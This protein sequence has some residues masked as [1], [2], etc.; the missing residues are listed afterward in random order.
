M[1]VHHLYVLRH[2]LR[3]IGVVEEHLVVDLLLFEQVHHLPALGI[4]NLQQ[5]FEMRNPALRI[6]IFIILPIA[7]IILYFSP[8]HIKHALA[9]LLNLF[10][11]LKF[12]AG[13]QKYLHFRTGLGI[14]ERMVDDDIEETSYHLHS[15]S[16]EELV[17]T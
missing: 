10:P 15:P 16:Y 8:I 3:R 7:K 14:K 5:P 13:R 12:L 9:A 2:P 1:P 6:S 11:G 17:F 4:E